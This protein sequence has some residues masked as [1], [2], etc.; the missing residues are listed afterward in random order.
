MSGFVI[1]LIALYTVSIA[2]LAYAIYT[3]PVWEDIAID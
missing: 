1:G 3:A 2:G